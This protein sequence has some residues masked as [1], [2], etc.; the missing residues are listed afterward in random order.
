M[1]FW[2]TN[3]PATFCTLMNRHPY[4]N[5]FVVVYL[6]D[7]VV[8]SGTRRR[9][10]EALTSHLL[11]ITRQPPLCQEGEVIFCSTISLVP[12]TSD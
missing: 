11:D 5:W 8:Y 10:R 6:D 12:R 1:L 4:L 3:A 7:I 2:L 9:A